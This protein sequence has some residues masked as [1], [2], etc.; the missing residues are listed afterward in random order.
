MAKLV[1]AVAWETDRKRAR[2]RD[3]TAKAFSRPRGEALLIIKWKKLRQ[4]PRADSL[5]FKWNWEEMGKAGT[6]SAASQAFS[7]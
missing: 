7:K 6:V 5:S 1:P 3:N 2:E 4:E